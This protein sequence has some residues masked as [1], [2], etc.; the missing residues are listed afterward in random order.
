MIV[1]SVF[2]DKLK[3]LLDIYELPL[4]QFTEKIPPSRGLYFLVRSGSIEYI[5][6]TKNFLKRLTKSHS[7]YNKAEHEVFVIVIENQKLLDG[8]E[9]ALISAIRPSLNQMY[10]P[11]NYLQ[12]AG[13]TNNVIMEVNISHVKEKNITITNG[14]NAI[15]YHYVFSHETF[16]V[17]A[18]QLFELLQYTSEKF[19]SKPRY[20]FLD[21]E[22]HRNENGGF[23][24]DMLELCQ[25][26]GLGVLLRYLTELHT[27]LIAARNQKQNDDIPPGLII[28]SASSDL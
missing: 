14:K 4:P 16:E 20:L 25:E 23:D 13:L 2:P 10:N 5:G 15:I 21:I 12:D 26:F 9:A 1:S 7:I 8:V 11:G 27:P 3:Q 18:G 22:E 17:A 19:P 28:K 24:K 6:K